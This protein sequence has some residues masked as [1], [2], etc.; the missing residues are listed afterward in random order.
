MQNRMQQP[1][2]SQFDAPSLPSQPQFFSNAAVA[3]PGPPTYNIP[4]TPPQQPVA[5]PASNNNNAMP[6]PSA[7][8][9]PLTQFMQVMQ[10]MAA[11][12]P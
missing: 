5:N 9:N 12:L 10:Y 7:D 1:G 6:P 2:S 11:H 3:Q 4:C 8:P